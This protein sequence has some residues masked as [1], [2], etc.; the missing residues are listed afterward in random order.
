MACGSPP[1]KVAVGDGLRDSS[2]PLAP[3]TTVFTYPM[4]PGRYRANGL[5]CSTGEATGRRSKA[6]PSSSSTRTDVARGP[7]IPVNR[8]SHWPAP[9]SVA[10]PLQPPPAT[11]ISSGRSGPGPTTVPAPGPP[12]SEQ[13][14]A[15]RDLASM[16]TLSTL[17]I[18]LRVL[19][20]LKLHVPPCWLRP[21]SSV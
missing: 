20:T 7:A 17:Q 4:Q 9:P 13:S 14:V 11:S 16:S 5:P 1:V 15:R 3:Y 19:T 12:A 18:P 8:L 10:P 21:C 6:R 2:T